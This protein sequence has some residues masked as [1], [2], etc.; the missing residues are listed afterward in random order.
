MGIELESFIK[1]KN[2]LMNQHL[3]IDSRVEL[4][5]CSIWW[6][7]SIQK[8]EAY[9]DKGTLVCQVLDV[10]A[11]IVQISIWS[12]VANGWDTATSDGVAWVVAEKIA[13]GI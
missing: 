1:V 6:L 13:L 9:L 10:E 8:N 4:T 5:E 2:F 12:R 3:I 11:P 7:I